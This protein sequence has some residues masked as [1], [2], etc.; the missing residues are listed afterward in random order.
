MIRPRFTVRRLALL[1]ALIAIGLMLYHE[2]NEGL[3]PRSVI[4]GIPAR[5]ARLK[6]GMTRQETMEILGL[7]KPWYRGGISSYFSECSGGGELINE[8]WFVGV[9]RS[10]SG[11]WW[12]GSRERG[13]LILNFHLNQD[14]GFSN[15]RYQSAPLT[16]A[17]FSLDD[18]LIAE[19]PRA[20]R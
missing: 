7:G 20:N 2:L 12:P 1:I 14:E 8:S 13:L 6:P 9:Q 5:I 3:P 19:M 10:F 16:S 18:R 4:H 17:S 15:D 11:K